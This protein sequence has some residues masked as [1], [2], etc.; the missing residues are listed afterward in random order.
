[1]DPRAVELPELDSELLPASEEDDDAVRF[2]V[3]RAG[4]A[5]GRLGKLRPTCGPASSFYIFFSVYFTFPF[6]LFCFVF[7]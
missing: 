7:Y 3:A 2:W 1:V 4:L 6:L 5:L